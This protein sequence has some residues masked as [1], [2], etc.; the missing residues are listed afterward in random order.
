MHVHIAMTYLGHLAFST[1]WNDL[2]ALIICIKEFEYE[3][4]VI[5]FP[6]IKLLHNQIYLNL[7]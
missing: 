2:L 1:Y 3:C 5:F 4:V 6:V 7:I